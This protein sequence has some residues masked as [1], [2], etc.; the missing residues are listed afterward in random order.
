ME[1]KIPIIVLTGDPSEN[2]R[3]KCINILKADAF[4]VKPVSILQLTSQ[5]RKIFQEPLNKSQTNVLEP[6]HKKIILIVED[7]ILLS[8]LFAHFL[9]NYNVMQAYTVEEVQYIYIYI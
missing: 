3:E 5:L 9:T 2:E 1:S 4:L 8:N 6:K 7:E